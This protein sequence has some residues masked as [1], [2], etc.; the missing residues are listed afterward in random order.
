M[1]SANREGLAWGTTC[2]EIHISINGIVV[3]LSYVPGIDS[4]TMKQGVAIQL[5]LT[6]SKT[7]VPVTFH[8]GVV[9]EPGLFD[10]KGQAPGPGEEL[11]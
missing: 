2:Q 3:E 10:S 8:D 6:E 11:D 4:P 7:A 1:L 9:M 5:V